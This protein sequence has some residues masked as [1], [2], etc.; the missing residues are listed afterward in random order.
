MSLA[1]CMTLCATMAFAQDAPAPAASDAPAPAAP[2]VTV[3]DLLAA[4]QKTLKDVKSISANMAMQQGPMKMSGSFVSMPPDN[5][6]MNLAA[7]KDS[8]MGE[9]TMQMTMSK[10]IMYSE[11]A[12]G[13]TRMVSKVDIKQV[14]EAA[15][16]AGLPGGFSVGADDFS[17]M[18][19]SLRTQGYDL[20][21]TAVKD[22][23][24]T[25]IADP[26]DKKQ[27]G[28][29]MQKMTLFINTKDGL[30]RE[31]HTAADMGMKSV[32]TLSDYKFNVGA[33]AEDFQYTV[34]EGVEPMDMTPTLLDM[35]KAQTPAAE[36][37]APAEQPAAPAAPAEQPAE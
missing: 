19:S 25:V 29:P 31:V 33:K 4:S 6:K 21:I 36:P 35:I 34:P 26:G 7:P 24:A 20:K 22:D 27:L 37:A 18:I 17:N 10:G 30:P 28:Q 5:M 2:T 15:E 12:Q 1:L 32:I 13:T 8:Q 14:R 23:L 9:M 16:K 11:I 3:D